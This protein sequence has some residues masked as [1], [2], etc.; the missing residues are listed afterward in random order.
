MSIRIEFYGICRH[1]AGVAS[2]D[3][4]AANLGD[5]IG[6]VAARLPQ[7]AGLCLADGRLQAGYVANVIGRTFTTDPATPLV[8]GDTVLF[9]SADVGG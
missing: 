2:I 7:L 4:A 6:Q 1:R 3:V 5:V 9:L 8:S